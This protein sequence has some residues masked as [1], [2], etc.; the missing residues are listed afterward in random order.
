MRR[1][2]R[3]LKVWQEAIALVENVYAVTRS[4]PKEEMFGLT[5]QMRRAAVSVPANIAEGAARTGPKEL[6][7]FVSI[8]VG[9]LS[10]LDTHVEIARRLGYLAENRLADRIDALGG[11]LMGLERAVKAKTKAA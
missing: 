6:A 2:H 3:G 1:G 7:R 4:F 8:A 9:S 11:L 5:A 10:E